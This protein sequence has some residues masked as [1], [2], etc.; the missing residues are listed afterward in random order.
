M[1]KRMQKTRPKW[2]DNAIQEA[3]RVVKENILS[4]RLAAG[5]FNVPFSCLLKII[6][7]IKIK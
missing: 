1:A 4:V 6:E 3:V 2:T 5:A 7:G